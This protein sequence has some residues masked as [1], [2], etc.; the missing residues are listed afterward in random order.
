MPLL[1]GGINVNVITIW[2][3]KTCALCSRCYIKPLAN[4]LV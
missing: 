1:S 4:M 2:Y 3:G